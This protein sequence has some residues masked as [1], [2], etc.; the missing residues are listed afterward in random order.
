M[1]VEVIR[2]IHGPGRRLIVSKQYQLHRLTGCVC[3][4][5][6]FPKYLAEKSNI[7]SN[8]WLLSIQRDFKDQKSHT[9]FMIQTTNVRFSKFHQI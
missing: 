7:C 1:C 3:S 9:R 4:S 5:L 6:L 2:Q 8:S